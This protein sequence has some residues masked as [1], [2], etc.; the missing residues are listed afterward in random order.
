M[1][2][3]LM[4]TQTSV[5]P[6]RLD[7]ILVSVGVIA[8]NR[9][10]GLH[11]TLSQIT[12]QSHKHLQ[13][14]V[15][16]NASTNMD[17]QRVAME[18]AEKDSRIRYIRQSSNIGAMG[19]FKFVLSQSTGEYFMWAADDD[20]WADTFIESCLRATNHSKISVGCKFETL[21]RV[22]GVRNSDPVPTLDPEL[23]VLENLKNFFSCVQPSLIYGLH[24]RTSLEFIHKLPS[25]DFMDCHIV[26]RQIVACGFRTIPEVLY[27]AGVD[28]PDY[29][30]KYVDHKS[31]KLDYASYF[32]HTASLFLRSR[33]IRTFEKH[34]AIALLWRSICNIVKHHES[35]DN[36]GKILRGQILGKWFGA[37]STQ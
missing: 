17:V 24:E 27:T 3:K 22:S 10:E 32:L 8:F 20:E 34:K 13:I 12:S 35:C 4:G 31:K 29:E 36:P 33:R 26:I 11:R 21:F 1:S 19:N 14:I 9:P 30:I 25:F 16:D 6:A 23:S 2:I 28:K 15:S 5:E 18:F 7:N 37:R